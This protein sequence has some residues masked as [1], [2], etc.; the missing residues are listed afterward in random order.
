MKIYR[1]SSIAA[2]S[3]YLVIIVL[4]WSDHQLQVHVHGRLTMSAIKPLVWS[5]QGQLLQQP[6]ALLYFTK[7]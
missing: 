1:E 2:N 5:D 7:V 6:V 4:Q 3:R